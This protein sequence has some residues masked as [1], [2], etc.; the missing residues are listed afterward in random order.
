MEETV[1]SSDL[2]YIGLPSPL[3]ILFLMTMGNDIRSQAGHKDLAT[4]LALFK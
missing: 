4:K 2:M 3:A 1:R